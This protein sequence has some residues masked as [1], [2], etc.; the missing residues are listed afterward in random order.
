MTKSCDL[1]AKY[2][3]H[4]MYIFFNKHNYN[5]KHYK[6]HL[7]TL[8]MHVQHIRINYYKVTAMKMSYILQ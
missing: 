7:R 1:N 2:C 6:I 5:I 8:I 3:F 4:Y